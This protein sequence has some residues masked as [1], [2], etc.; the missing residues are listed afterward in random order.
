MGLSGG[1]FLVVSEEL[2][3]QAKQVQYLKDLN[4]PPVEPLRPIECKNPCFSTDYCN[5]RKGVCERMTDMRMLRAT[6][7]PIAKAEPAAPVAKTAPVAKGKQ[8]KAA[9]VKGLTASNITSNSLLLTWS[10][11]PGQDG[12][13]SITYRKQNTRVW[14][15]LA[16]KLSVRTFSVTGLT[17]QTNYH[18]RVEAAGRFSTIQAQTSEPSE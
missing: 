13:Y 7:A 10:A 14:R 8:G 5:L 15:N 12:P 18:F 16:E 4:V 1:G 17:P 2:V 9:A 3:S 11:I 6:P